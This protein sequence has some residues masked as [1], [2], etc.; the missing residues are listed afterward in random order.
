MAVPV[1][2]RSFL[3]LVPACGIVALGACSKSPEPVAKPAAVPPPVAPAPVATPPAPA[4]QAGMPAAGSALLG[5][6]DPQALA[7]GYVADAGRVDKSRFKT[8][9][10][11]SSC[12]GCSQYTGKS[13]D[14]A[15]GCRIF[16][17][18]NVAAAGWCTAWAKT[19]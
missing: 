4:P 3:R 1:S 13:G 5:E 10:A 6:Q 16:P 19:A 11:G 9:V 14:A 12:D 7:L 15:G 17:A 2:R 18:R 8:F